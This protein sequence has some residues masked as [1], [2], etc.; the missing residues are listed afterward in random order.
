MADT[1]HDGGIYDLNEAMRIWST[2]PD[3]RAIDVAM[4]DFGMPMGPLRL[5]D[6]I[7]IDVAACIID[8]MRGYYAGRFEPST[9]AAKLV[10]ASL[11]GRK[12]GTGFYRYSS[13]GEVVNEEAAQ[14][15][16]AAPSGDPSGAAQIRGRLL[17]LMVREARA[18]IDE[19]VVKS[20][21]NIDFAMRLGT[22]FPASRGGLTHWSAAVGHPLFS[23]SPNLGFT[24]H[25][26]SRQNRLSPS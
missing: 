25:A 8:G 6:E 7:G 22:G 11:K 18:C 1:G 16:G 3:T 4:I 10:G 9:A 14:V 12:S 15:A 24:P 5:I 21:E 19:G 20:A 17:G 26:K 23:Y 13:S 2:Q